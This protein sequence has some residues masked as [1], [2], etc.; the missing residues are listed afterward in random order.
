MFI[1]F[2][3]TIT[4]SVSSLVDGTGVNVYIIDTGV[5]PIHEDLAGRVEVFYDT[6]PIRGNVRTPYI[7]NEVDL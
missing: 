6:E 7:F 2:L 4:S 3:Q 1:F 5:N